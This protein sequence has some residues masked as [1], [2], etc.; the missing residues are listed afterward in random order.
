MQAGARPNLKVLVNAPVAKILSSSL[1]GSEFVASGVEFLFDGATHTVQTTSNGEV[2]ISAGC[3]S[4]VCL[5]VY[6]SGKKR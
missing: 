1:A 4:V 2:I 5:R 3:V 6:E